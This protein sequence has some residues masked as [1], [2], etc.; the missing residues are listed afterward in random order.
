MLVCRTYLLNPMWLVSDK[1]YILMKKLEFNKVSKKIKIQVE[2]CI[3][4]TQANIYETKRKQWKK[5]IWKEQTQ[6]LIGQNINI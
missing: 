2:I 6:I 1:W 5:I 3:H 4:F